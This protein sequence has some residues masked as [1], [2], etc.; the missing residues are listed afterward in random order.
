MTTKLEKFTAGAIALIFDEQ[1]DL[2]VSQRWDGRWNLPGGGVDQGETI[3]D[4]LKREV[5]EETGLE[6]RPNILI[7]VYR[8][9]VGGNK[10][11]GFFFLCE[12]VGGELIGFVQGEVR[13]NRFLNP[14]RIRH[15]KEFIPRQLQVVEDL[16]DGKYGVFR[17]YVYRGNRVHSEFVIKE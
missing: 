14:T 12:I 2:L 6:V 9:E 11:I 16:L 1:G 10:T 5:E 7:E 3:T 15:L 4:A 17:D 13:G 8:S